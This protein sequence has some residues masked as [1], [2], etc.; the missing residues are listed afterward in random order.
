MPAYGL[1][2]GKSRRWKPLHVHLRVRPRATPAS[3]WTHVLI[4]HTCRAADPQR[5]ALLPVTAPAPTATPPRG[6]HPSA[7]Q[8]IPRS[9]ATK[10]A[11]LT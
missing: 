5:L 2:E 1:L 10:I 11:R 6:A 9:C 8:C 3:A 7:A 4:R